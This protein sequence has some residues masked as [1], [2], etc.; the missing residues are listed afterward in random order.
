MNVS[1]LQA[2]ALTVRHPLKKLT[3]PPCMTPRQKSNMFIFKTT[4]PQVALHSARSH[5]PGQT[6]FNQNTCVVH[7]FVHRFVHCTPQD[8]N[9]HG[10]TQQR[11]G[12]T[13]SVNVVSRMAVSAAPV[14]SCFH[15]SCGAV[16]SPGSAQLVGAHGLGCH[17]RC[18]L[19]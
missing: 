3:P 7:T 17:W 5:T 11:T 12:S 1:H 6:G 19:A 9:L 10:S 2:A 18:S 14:V 4:L 8:C 13:T 15:T 16:V